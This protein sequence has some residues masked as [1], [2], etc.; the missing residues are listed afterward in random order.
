[1]D[2]VSFIIVFWVI[3]YSLERAKSGYRAQRDQHANQ[4]AAKNPTWS[5]KR[6]RRA[7][8]RR[9]TAWWLHE[10]S[11][12]FPSIR[13]AW[14]EDLE[15]IRHMRENDRL[16]SERRRDTLRAELDKLRSQRAR[17]KELTQSGKTKLSFPQ[18]IDAGCP[19]PTPAA[20]ATTGTPPTGTSPGTGTQAPPDTPTAPGTPASTNG[21]TSPTTGKPHLRV[22]PLTPDG[23]SD[24]DS[25]PGTN[26]GQP[27][28]PAPNSAPA[29]DSAR[30]ANGSAPDA[31]AAAAG[32]GTA[33]AAPGGTG[34]A[35]R[36]PQTPAASAAANG[37][38][39]PASPT[40]D[41]SPTAA[42]V[43]NSARPDGESLNGGSAVEAPN[44]E[45]ALAI[46]QGKVRESQAAASGLEQ[47][48]NDL[49]A[50]GMGQD[51][52]T[53]NGIRAAKEMTE[54]AAAE[55]QKV[56]TGLQKHTQ[57][58]EYANT[59]FAAKTEFLKS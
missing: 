46:A 37:S 29:P 20:P 38:Q 27:T 42:P 31:T 40:G 30:P 44:Y 58:V 33:P 35:N 3:A 57:G 4:I 25:K 43:A 45:S 26:G 36:T 17:H 21:A 9:A 10:A 34:N 22:V 2:P 54:Q 11:N 24:T 41:D 7:A 19:E 51:M 47:Y 49:I 15:H 18:W 50:G 39:A 8:N 12:G 14:A 13:S 28:T 6:V 55:W 52:E 59:G 56:V 32:A 5:Q 23:K 53:L 1:M 48:E 16:A